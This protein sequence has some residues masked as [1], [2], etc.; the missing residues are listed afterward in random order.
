MSTLEKA[1]ALA[2]TKHAGQT[3]RS[4][5]PYILHP[6]H[7]MQSVTQIDEKIVAVLHDVLEDTDIT[8]NELYDM[9]FSEHI[10]H[11]IQ[12]LTKI[13]GEK[14]IDAARRTAKNKLATIVKL[15]DVA[16]NMDMSRLKVVSRKDLVRLEE[17]KEVQK[18][19]L[20][21]LSSYD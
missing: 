13:E 1:I 2:A 4:G 19:L 21:A 9:G 8:T 12:A 15:A 7:V 18:I 10:I 5:A 14:R 17:Y 11:A 6:L 20:E 16:H 3:D